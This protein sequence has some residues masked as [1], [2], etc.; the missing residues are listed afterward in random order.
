MTRLTG[1]TLIVLCML[2]GYGSYSS[3]MKFDASNV[4]A[5]EIVHTVDYTLPRYREH[6]ISYGT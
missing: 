2:M 6:P 1:E 4:T 5:R 3:A